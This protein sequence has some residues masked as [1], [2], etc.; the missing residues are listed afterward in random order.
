[1][2]MI[3]CL[4]QKDLKYKLISRVRRLL[5]DELCAY[6][7]ILYPRN[8]IPGTISTDKSCPCSIMERIHYLRYSERRLMLRHSSEIMDNSRY[9]RK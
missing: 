5:I 2:V 7:L 8:Y 9:T 1:M 3:I 4:I 6:N